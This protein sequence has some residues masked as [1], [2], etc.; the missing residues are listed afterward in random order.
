MTIKG[1]SHFREVMLNKTELREKIPALEPVFLTASNIE[2]GCKCNRTGR[3]QV[4]TETYVNVLQN[5]ITA[6]DKQTMKDIMLKDIGDIDTSNMKI[7]FRH[8][9][10]TS[11]TEKI[12]ATIQ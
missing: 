5:Y 1:P 11:K 10:L 9:D 7:E 6:E 3:L 4:A 2:R 12:T 8:Y